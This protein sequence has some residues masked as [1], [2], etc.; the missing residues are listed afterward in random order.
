MKFVTYLLDVV[1]G[2]GHTLFTDKAAHDKF[3]FPED[4]LSSTKL[5]AILRTVR[6]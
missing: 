1:L 5:G 6:N 2:C 4:R 3:D